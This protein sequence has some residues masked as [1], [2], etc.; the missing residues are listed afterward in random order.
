MQRKRQQ[1]N[2]RMNYCKM[3][4]SLTRGQINLAMGGP[5]FK[6]FEY[7]PFPAN[8][9]R[10][11]DKTGTEFN[12]RTV[13]RMNVN[14][15]KN[16]LLEAFDRPDTLTSCPVRAVSTFAP[17]ALILMNGP[18][19]QEQSKRFAARLL[20]ACGSDVPRQIDLAY[21]LALTRP[22]RETEARMALDFLLGQT[23]LIRDRLR[24]QLPVRL[25]SEMPAHA[26][27]A[28]ASA[29]VDFCLALLN[30]NEFLYVN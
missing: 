19:V 12:R 10:P 18:F 4:R 26:D 29:L 17:Q 30:R 14:S 5:S 7:E 6:P 9:Y 22:P 28:A 23:D 15:G 3:V 16:P 8:V 13:Y 11:V 21:R 24:A 25:P 27:P 2:S 1:P 20:R